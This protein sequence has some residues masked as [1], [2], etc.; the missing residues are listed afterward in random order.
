M[1]GA[2]THLTLGNWRNFKKVD[3][4]LQSRVFIVGANA[5]GKS[6]LVDAFR[7]LQELAV[8]GGGLTNA[9]EG[10]GR[11][12]IRSVRSLHAGGEGGR[13]PNVTLG[14]AATI[15]GVRWTYRLVLQADGTSQKHGPARIKEECVTRDDA[16]L[17][18]RPSAADKK[19]P[20]LLLETA[21]EQRSANASF[22]ELRAFLQSVEYIHVVPQLVR[23]PAQGDAR[24][25]GKGLGTG[26]IAAMG[27]VP[28]KTRDA[29]LKRIQRALK[30]VLPQFEAL[31]WE[32]DRRGVPHIRAKYKHWRPRGAWQDETSFSDGTLRLI[33]LLWYLAE[34]GGPLLLE[35]PELSLHPAAVRQIPRILGNVGTKS[36]RQVF[37]T[38]HSADLTADKGID[39]SEVLLLR[40]N[41]SET[42]VTVGSDVPEL[43]RAA[44]D[45]LALAPHIEA[46]TRPDEYAQ[47]ALFGAEP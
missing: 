19:D 31:E 47:L 5:S 18:T 29:R 26:L 20:E 39:P 1:R 22:R 37:M 16:P 10:S 23:M 34:G 27:E 4:A 32:Q 7:F 3:V 40:T 9:L 25:F 35:E 36:A 12:G 14:V 45:D 15:D 28:K 24:R 38:S 46:L 8:D 42:T 21:L 30:S 44:E 13:S 2:F 43:T 33:G 17:L 6:N 41:G 11:G